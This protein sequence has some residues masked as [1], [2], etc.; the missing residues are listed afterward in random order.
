MPQDKQAM[1]HLLKEI[2]NDAFKSQV[3]HSAE[4][5]FTE[6]LIKENSDEDL[7]EFVVGINKLYQNK[8]KLDGVIDQSF[9]E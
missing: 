4:H 7:R 1:K 5:F 2:I 6:T 9:S 8:V 3:R